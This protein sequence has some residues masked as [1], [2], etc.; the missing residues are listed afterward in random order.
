MEAFRETAAWKCLIGWCQSSACVESGTPLLL[1]LR[2]GCQHL[3]F[4][5]DD[6]PPATQVT[7]KCNKTPTQMLHIN[8]ESLGLT[9]TEIFQSGIGRM[10]LEFMVGGSG[11]RVVCIDLFS[12]IVE[13]FSETLLSPSPAS[14]EQW[15]FR[16]QNRILY[17]AH[18][19]CLGRMLDLFLGRW[20]RLY[21]AGGNPDAFYQGGILEGEHGVLSTRRGFLPFFLS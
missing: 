5:F 1:Q 2:Q 6:E 17:D 9:L 16:D 21:L 7:G 11:S 10:A 4:E 20:R 13:V 14:L 15:L 18:C 19:A 3:H 8:A 12:D